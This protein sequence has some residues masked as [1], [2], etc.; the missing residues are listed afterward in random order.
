MITMKNMAINDGYSEGVSFTLQGE[1]YISFIRHN[2]KNM[3]HL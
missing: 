2:E 1:S 3:N